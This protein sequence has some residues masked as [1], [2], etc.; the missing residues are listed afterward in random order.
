MSET[1]KSEPTPGP[2]TFEP[3]DKRPFGFSIVGGA[4]QIVFQQDAVAFSSEQ[5][6]R[7]DCESGVGFSFH[8]RNRISEMIAE[9]DAN[10]RLIAAAPDLLAACKA[11]DEFFDYCSTDPY[12]SHDKRELRKA[13]K[14]AIAKATG[15]A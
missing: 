13:I 6:T 15:A 7:A 9:Q 1:K 8:E 4:R 3:N 5:R 2:W 10:G 11:V 12:H 14:A